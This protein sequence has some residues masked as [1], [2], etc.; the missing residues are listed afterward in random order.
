MNHN[1][2]QIWTDQYTVHSYEV[3]INKKLTVES[4]LHYF[5]ESAWNHEE[6]LDIGFNAPFMNGKLWV[7]SKIILQIERSALWGETIELRTWARGVQALYALRDFDVLCNGFTLACGASFWLVIDAKT[8][9]PQRLDS[10]LHH[11]PFLPDN[12]L[13]KENHQIESSIKH[14]NQSKQLKPSYSDLDFN[15][16]VNNTRYIRWV[17]DSYKLNFL[18]EHELK[19][20]QIQYF[21]EVRYEDDVEIVT[22]DRSDTVFMHTIRRLH[23]SK[24]LCRLSA[25]WKKTN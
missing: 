15:L 2:S 4:L 17:I 8:R 19:E 14:Y 18:R 24:D 25:V 11:V 5:Q 16:H 20:M 9:R 13:C 1:Y 10:L 6:H 3:D 22:E 21:A 23:D 12:A 7:L